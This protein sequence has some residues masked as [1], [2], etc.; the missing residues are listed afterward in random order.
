[1]ENRTA[2]V[3]ITLLVVFLCAFPALFFLCIGVLALIEILS[4]HAIQ[5]YGYNAP[6]WLA[7]GLCVGLLGIAIAVVVAVLVLRL[8]KKSTPPPPP[9]MPAPPEEPLPPTI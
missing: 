9:T 3:I 5:I 6:Y 1:M 2:A 4:N 7:G 8:P